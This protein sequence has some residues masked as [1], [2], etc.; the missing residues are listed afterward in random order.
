MLTINGSPCPCLE[1]EP[2]PNSY[3][4]IGDQIANYLRTGVS[5]IPIFAY[6]DFSKPIPESSASDVFDAIAKTVKARIDDMVPGNNLYVNVDFTGI[7]WPTADIGTSRPWIGDYDPSTVLICVSRVDTPII[8]Q[9][10]S[11]R[12][13]TRALSSKFARM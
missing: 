6:M 9:H 10:G 7:R 1:N 3:R 4:T 2:C 5:S 11:L 13:A 8:P 12:G